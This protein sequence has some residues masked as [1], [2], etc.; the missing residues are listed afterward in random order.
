M[1]IFLGEKLVGA[2]FYAFCNY[3]PGGQQWEVHLPPNRNCGHQVH[4]GQYFVSFIAFSCGQQEG[5]E[6]YFILSHFSQFFPQVEGLT[7]ANSAFHSLMLV[8][9]Y[10]PDDP[11]CKRD[12]VNVHP[13]FFFHTSPST[14]YPVG[15]N[16]HVASQWWRD[17]PVWKRSRWRLFH[18]VAMLLN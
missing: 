9:S 8:N 16:L 10:Q 6:L 15:E 7:I 18:Q 4:Q 11:T 12:I 2:N 5:Q 1:L 3:V 14:R 17:Q 13:T